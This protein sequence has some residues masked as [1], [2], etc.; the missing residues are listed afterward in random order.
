LLYYDKIEFTKIICSEI[1]KRYSIAFDAIGGYV[2]TIGD[3]ATAD[4]VQKYID[5]QGT[6][7]E[8][9]SYSR[10]KLINFD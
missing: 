4:I 2:G 8:L 1:G 9:E 6:R 10:L 5:E 3:N 7:E